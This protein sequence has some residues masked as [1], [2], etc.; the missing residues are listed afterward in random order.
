MSVPPSSW[1]GGELRG[2]DLGGLVAWMTGAGGGLCPPLGGRRL[3]LAGSI[4]RGRLC[5]EVEYFLNILSDAALI[6]D[7]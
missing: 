4:G 3:Y 6:G 7:L 5:G 2:G 1:G